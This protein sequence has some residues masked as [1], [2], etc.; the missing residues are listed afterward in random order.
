[1]EMFNPLHSGTILL[2]DWIKPLNIT[3]SE[4]A[5]KVRTSRK[6]LSEIV[7]CKTGICS[8][9]ALKLSKALKTSTKLWLNLQLAYDLWKAKQHVNFDEVEVIALQIYL[10]SK[11]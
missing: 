1:M 11:I 2:E 8:E 10:S 4:F 5:L 6:N 7:N 3:I 9:M